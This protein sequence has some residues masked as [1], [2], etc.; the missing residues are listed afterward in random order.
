[1]FIKTNVYKQL[2]K[3]LPIRYLNQVIQLFLSYRIVSDVQRTRRAKSAH[4][5][6]L[7]HKSLHALAPTNINILFGFIK[8]MNNFGKL[9]GGGVVATFVN[10]LSLDFL[11]S[12]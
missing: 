10:V 6:M 3:L 9:Y 4:N 11:N 2:K 5:T 1:M 8:K 12:G 7:S